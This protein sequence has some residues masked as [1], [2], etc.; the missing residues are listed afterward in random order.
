MRVPV[1]AGY[2]FDFPPDIKLSVFT[3]P[4][5]EVGLSGKEHANVEGKKYSESVYGDEGGMRRFDLLWGVGAGITYQSYYF[6]VS[7]GI[8]MLNMVDEDYVKFHENRVT[9]TLGYNF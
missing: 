1:M 5:L 4:E 7:G 8:G 2:H 9:L 3:G 6:G